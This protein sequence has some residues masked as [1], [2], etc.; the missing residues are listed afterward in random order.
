MNGQKILYAAV[1][2]VVGAVAG[3]VFADRANRKELDALRSEVAQARA[4]KPAIRQ[5]ADDPGAQPNA[6]ASAPAM[7]TAQEMRDIIAKADARAD[8]GNYQ[9]EVGQGVYMYSLAQN[10]PALMPEAIRLLK[11]AEKSDPKN[12]QTVLLLGNAHF[13]LAQDGDAK[14]YPEARSYYLRALETKPDD[15]NL[16]ALL[17]MTYYFGSPPDAPRAIAEYRK[18]LAKNPRHEMALQNIAAALVSTGAL[19]EAQRRLKELES[20]NPQN[21]ALDNLR[22]QLAQARNA[23]RK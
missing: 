1:A 23:G 2:L 19:E 3:F 13:A 5:G 16:H 14:L 17:G 18:S 9:R 11:R 8:D 12:F 22:A 20:V 21:N 6:P 15:A 4:G 10:D 7:P